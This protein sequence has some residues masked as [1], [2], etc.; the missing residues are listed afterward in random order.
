MDLT[1]QRA[2]IAAKVAAASAAAVAEDAALTLAQRDF[3]EAFRAYFCLDASAA[4]AKRQILNR[5][6]LI[7]ASRMVE[8]WWLFGDKATTLVVGLTDPLVIAAADFA[9]CKRL[10]PPGAAAPTPVDRS[11]ALAFARRLMMVGAAD[12]QP[13]AAGALKIAGTDLGASLSPTDPDRWRLFS[14]YGRLPNDGADFAVMIARQD[15][16]DEISTNEAASLLTPE[17]I[18]KVRKISVTA[19]CFGGFFEA[20]LQR[21]LAF[22]PGDVVP[23]DWKGDGAALLMLGTQQFATGTIGDHNGRRAIR[24]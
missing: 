13:P 5:R 2:F 1:A 14:F 11:I 7:A 10:S 20:T 15:R 18:A 16:S 12:G 23:I 21:I 17:N 8:S 19:Q 24:L 6:Q 4:R 3:T 22:K 9:T